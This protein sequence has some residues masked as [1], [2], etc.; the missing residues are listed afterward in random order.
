[1]RRL[2]EQSIVVLQHL[3]GRGSAWPE[4]SAAAIRDLRSRMMRRP[5]DNS[6]IAQSVKANN[7]AQRPR[8]LSPDSI[9]AAPHHTAPIAGAP[10]IALGDPRYGLAGISQPEQGYPFGAFRTAEDMQL[11]SSS[12]DDWRQQDDPYMYVSDNAS[13]SSFL[14]SHLESQGDNTG[15]LDVLDP[16]S[17]FDIPFWFEQDQHWDVF[18]DYNL[19][20]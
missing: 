15:Y 5:I 3:A 2:A 13:F 19:G 16:F 12:L 1:M 10:V 20:N 17:G 18:Q 9:S 8:R 14:D 7:V 6:K 11:H 4:A